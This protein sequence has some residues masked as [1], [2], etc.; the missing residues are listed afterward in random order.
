MKHQR[1]T[2]MDVYE[3]EDMD[4]YNWLKGNLLKYQ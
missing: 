2:L 3:G 1:I 4:G